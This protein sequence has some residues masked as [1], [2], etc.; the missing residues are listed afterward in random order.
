MNTNDPMHILHVRVVNTSN[1]PLPKYETFGAAGMDLRANLEGVTLKHL[2]GAYRAGDKVVI[3][4]GGRVLI[5]TGIHIKLHP[6]YEAQVRPRS[7]LAL[8][9]GISIVNSPGTIDSDYVG[10]I[11]VVLIN[12][13]SENFTVEHGDRIA[14]LVIAKHETVSWIEVDEL[15][16]TDR[17]S[18]GFGTTGVQ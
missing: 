7:G 8:K 17:I 12:Q 10:D 14:Q 18:D 11:G 15:E 6:G 5:P 4:P 13:G 3:T 9:H 2:Y 1:N 16:E